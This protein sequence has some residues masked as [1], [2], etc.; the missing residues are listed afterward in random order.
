MD[1]YGLKQGAGRANLR[2]KRKQ[3]DLYG[4]KNKGAGRANLRKRETNGLVE[5]IN[6]ARDRQPKDKRENK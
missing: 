4:A 6:R 5:A 3:M 2:K 1:K